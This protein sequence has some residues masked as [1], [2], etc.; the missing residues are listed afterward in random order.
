MVFLSIINALLNT[1]NVD[2]LWHF[3]WQ[4][5]DSS[6]NGDTGILD[7]PDGLAHF[8]MNLEELLVDICQLLGS[9]TFVQKVL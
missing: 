4:V 3:L 5:D 7:M 1:V 9:T 6:Y 8:R 2:Y